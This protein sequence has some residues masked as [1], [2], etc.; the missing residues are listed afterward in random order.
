MKSL[1][2][3]I[4]STATSP[5]HLSTLLLGVIAFFFLTL[6]V[7]YQAIDESFEVANDP[8]A[9]RRS[10]YYGNS[11]GRSIHQMMMSSTRSFRGI[12]G[13]GASYDGGRGGYGY[14]QPSRQRPPSNITHLP[15]SAVRPNVKKLRLP[16]EI[17]TLKPD[18]LSYDIHECPP[19]IPD[20]YPVAW[21][22]IDV[23]TNWNPDDTRV[24]PQG[25][26]QGLCELDWRD[27]EQ[28]RLAE[29][30]YRPAEVPFILKNHETV[31]ETSLRW[32]HKSYLQ[33]K[34]GDTPMRNEYSKNNHLMYWKVRGDNP[35]KKKQQ[36]LVSSGGKPQGWEPPTENVELTY[37]EWYEKASLLES[38]IQNDNHTF[39]NQEH[40]YF[41]LNGDMMPGGGRNEFLFDELPFFDP[42]LGSTMFMVDPKDARGINCRLGS[43]GTIA[44]THYDFSRN[45]ILMLGG[46]KR[47][48]LAHPSQC[49]P[50]ELYPQ[51]HPSARHSRIN[52]SDPNDWHTGKFAD[53]LVTEVVLQAGDM[54]YLPT[55]WFH[56]IVS[57][58]LNYQCNARS[59]ITWES[60]QHIKDCGF[61]VH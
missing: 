16:Y 52:W 41:R 15:S 21:N 10:S 29:K 40:W 2:M 56:F 18:D 25:I 22:T 8:V 26:H 37:E 3:G 57:L 31:W 60:Q 48:V 58:N 1:M 59:G 9:R 39:S 6:F 17:E 12:G 38:Q 34:L 24:P 55:A 51:E 27:K 7:L 35:T 19:N 54:L 28:R 33:E 43:R 36:G 30:V 32:S 47:Y 4:S 46:R 13:G 61:P 14:G 20:G 42:M 49:Q 50:M 44:E 5:K 53:G 11:F 45:W 23:L